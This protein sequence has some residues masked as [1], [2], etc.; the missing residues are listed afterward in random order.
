MIEVSGV[1]YTR[2][3]EMDGDELAK[4]RKLTGQLH[5]LTYETS[6]ADMVAELPHEQ[7]LFARAMQ[8]HMSIFTTHS[9]SLTCGKGLATKSNLRATP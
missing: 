3:R 4:L 1:L 8:E 6:K 9:S 2:S 7:Q 5:K